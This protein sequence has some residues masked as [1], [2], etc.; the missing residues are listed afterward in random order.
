MDRGCRAFLCFRV[1]EAGTRS[2]NLPWRRRCARPALR[3]EWR[4]ISYWRSIDEENQNQ[5]AERSAE[6]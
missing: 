6:T 2:Q 1:Q 3:L 5:V 4:V